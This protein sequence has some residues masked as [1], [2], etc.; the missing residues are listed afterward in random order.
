MS[1]L[2]IS[3]IRK[4]RELTI[5]V[6]KFTFTARRPTDVEALELHRNGGASPEIA[7][8]FVVGWAGV[9]SNDVVGDSSSDVLPF[10]ADLWREWC[11]DRP[12]FWAPI[13]TKILEAYGVHATQVEEATKKSLP[14]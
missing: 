9:T 8:K 6:D 13:A 12:D 11:A 1:S 10:D 5:P 2:L 3:K 14:G 4:N 7:A